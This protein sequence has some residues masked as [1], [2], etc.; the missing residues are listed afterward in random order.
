MENLSKPELDQCIFDN[1]LMGLKDE[2]IAAK[3]NVKMHYV[4]RTIDEMHVKNIRAKKRLAKEEYIANYK[5]LNLTNTKQFLNIN[6]N[7]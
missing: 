3:F 7:L 1:F 4:R 6:L 5:P 2:E